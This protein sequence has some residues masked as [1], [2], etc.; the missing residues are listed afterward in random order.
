M[1]RENTH[2]NRDDQAIHVDRQYA[3]T[4]LRIR[5]NLDS[6][7][8]FNSKYAAIINLRTID[9]FTSLVWGS[10]LSHPNYNTEQSTVVLAAIGLVLSSVV[11]SRLR[12][13]RLFGNCTIFYVYRLR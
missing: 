12:A 1:P 11:G 4:I 6:D 13:G 2:N 9:T 8:E 5:N 10:T 3:L 7:P